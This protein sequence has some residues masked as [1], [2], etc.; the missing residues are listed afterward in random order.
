MAT[1]IEMPKLS[2]TMTT[3]KILS[4]IK[5]EGDPVKSGQ[6][7]AEVETDKA[8]MELEVFD[9]GVLLKILA[10]KDA[11]VPIGGAL[12]IVGKAGEDISALIEKAQSNTTAAPPKPKPADKKVTV[13][14][15][16]DTGTATPIPEPAAIPETGGR[17]RISPVAQRIAADRNIDIRQVKGSGPSGRIVKR[18]VEEFQGAAAAPISAP[19][20]TVSPVSGEPYQDIPLSS[21]RAVIANRLPLSLGPI[22]HFYL[23]MD[24][25]AAPLLEANKQLKELSGDIR[26]TLTDLLIKACA[27]ALRKHPQ[28]NS[29]FAGTAVR[30]FNIVNIG[31][32]VAGDGHLLVPVIPRCESK[33]LE[34]I[35]LDRATLVDKGQKGRLSVEEMSN[36]TF[37]ISNLGMFGITRFQAI[38]N[39]PQAA[40]LAVGTV[41]EEP[42]VKNSQIVPGKRMSLSLSCDHRVFDGAEGAEF[43][44]TL[45]KILETP[46]ALCL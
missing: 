39:P 42:V 1:I 43:M 27:V 21:M 12:A 14:L 46:A 37:T 5:K 45:K 7:I 28:V 22:P 31:L 2:D 36:G 15:A 8:T 30:R 24:I 25:D 34:Q 35:A 3:G 20:F 26:I 23:E 18:D 16:L 32:A 44:A 40:I 17:I 11:S 29:Q 41:R 19:V 38:I 10:E 4:W 6:A 33:T 13:T 9:D